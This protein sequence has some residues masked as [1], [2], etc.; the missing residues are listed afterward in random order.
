MKINKMKKVTLMILLMCFLQAW[1]TAVAQINYEESKVPQYTLPDPLVTEEGDSVLSVQMWQE[2][3]RPELIRLF[4]ENVY[5]KIPQNKFDRNFRVIST[6][7]NALDG[8]A[9]RKQVEIKIGDEVKF[10]TL[11]L[12]IYIP[13]KTKKPVPAFLGFNF[14]G[15]QTVNSDTGIFITKNWVGN[16]KS[17][18]ITENK[19]TNVSRGM[20]EHR[21]PVDM[22]VKHGY[23][24]ATAYYGDID[25]D[26][27]D[28]F[29]NG[30]HS[31]VDQNDHTKPAPDE[32]G[33]ISAWALGYSFALDYLIEDPDINGDKIVVM[34]HSRLGKTALW[35]GALD[36]RFALVISNESGCGGAALSRRRFGETVK[37]I[38]TSFPHWFCGNFKKY[39]DNE[40]SLP[41]DQHELIALIAPRPVYVTAAEEDLWADPYGMFLA[42]KYATPVFELFGK[43][44]IPSGAVMQTNDPLTNGDIWF[45]MR[46][47][48]HNVTEYDWK[49]FIKFA[50]KYLK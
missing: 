28:G 49:Q 2:V 18:G 13:N 41:V 43:N 37:R 20:R 38:N 1:H 48:K 23:A 40:D 36:T 10:I 29:K 14:Y 47:G 16:N 7:K 8:L 24:L 19:A 17:M 39:N 27:D 26:F 33:S 15:N 25:P 34:G 5:G 46:S 32:W 31:L 30:I 35:A 11:N 21:W 45:H 50:D 6:D 3:R 12:L 4:A 44:G 9:T 22:I 42:C